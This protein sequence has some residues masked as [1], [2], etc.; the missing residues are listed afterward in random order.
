M[1][2]Q[3]GHVSYLESVLFHLR[4]EKENTAHPSLSRGLRWLTHISWNPGI[5]SMRSDLH[6][7]EA[8]LM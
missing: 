5:L 8:D 1:G 7:T 3:G 4:G 6:N 2:Q